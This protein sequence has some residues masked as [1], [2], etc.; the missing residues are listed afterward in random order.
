MSRHLDKTN[1]ENTFFIAPGP[2]LKSLA[3]LS[4]FSKPDSLTRSELVKMLDCSVL[5]VE[6]NCAFLLE[7]ESKDDFGFLTNLNFDQ[8]EVFYTSN[9][10]GHLVQNVTK[11]E[12][13]NRWRYEKV[14]PR[15]VLLI[16]NLVADFSAD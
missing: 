10:F 7:D 2:L 5:N 8:D 9:K 3:T 12:R 11:C 6:N 13:C 16:T 4:T 14:S 15:E 1:G